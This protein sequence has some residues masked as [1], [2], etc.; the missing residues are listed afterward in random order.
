MV[1]A[2]FDPL[3]VVVDWL[4]ACSARRLDLLLQLYEA[5]ATLECACDGPR[6]YRGRRG[7]ASYWVD[8]LDTAVDGAFQ[9]INIVPGE[10]PHSVVL[11]HLSYQ[12]KPVRIQ[13]TFA[14]SGKIAATIC[15]P[16]VC[17]GAA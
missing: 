13:F 12:G 15:A 7:I 11:D 14:P 4:E 1:K 16:T 8:R 9:L 17:S 5:G 10:E 6:T 2:D 3:G